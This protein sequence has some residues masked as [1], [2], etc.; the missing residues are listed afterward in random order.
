MT[1]HPFLSASTVWGVL[2]GEHTFRR[3][4][5]LTVEDKEGSKKL[6]SLAF[7]FLYQGLEYLTVV[8]ALRLVMFV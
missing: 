3:C 5:L 7:S 8:P 1:W 2:P 6:S 4:R